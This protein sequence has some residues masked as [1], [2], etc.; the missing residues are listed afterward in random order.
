MKVPEGENLLGFCITCFRVRWLARV[1]SHDVKGNPLGVCR[2][3][4]REE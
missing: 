4:E 1:T 3:C 2:S